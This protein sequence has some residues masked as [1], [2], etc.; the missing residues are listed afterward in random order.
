MTPSDSYPPFT[1]RTQTLNMLNTSAFCIV[2]EFFLCFVP[3]FQAQ[4]FS[5]RMAESSSDNTEIRRA[6]NSVTQNLLSPALQAQDG[7]D[8]STQPSKRKRP[9]D[10]EDKEN[11]SSDDMPKNYYSYGRIFSRQ[12]CPFNT[13]DSIVNFGIRHEASDDDDSD[14]EPKTL[15]TLE[16]HQLYGWKLICSVIPGFCI[17]MLALAKQRKVRKAACQHISKGAN[18]VRSDDTASL[19]VSIPE[20]LLLNVKDVLSPPMLSKT[21][22]KNDRG[23]YHPVT[24][25][26]LSPVKYPKD[27]LT[28]EGIRAGTLPVTAQLL[29]S[30]L[31]PDGHVYDPNDISLN[32][33]RGH[34]MIRVAKH[35][36]QGPSTALEQ[37]GAHRGKQGNASLCGLTTMTPHTIAYVAIQARFAMTSTSTWANIDGPFSYSDFYWRIVGLFEDE[38]EAADIIKFYNHH[39]F[40]TVSDAD[41]RQIAAAEDESEDEYEI[42]RRQ[43]SA[44]RA[45]KA[46]ERSGSVEA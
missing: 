3:L 36:F 27:P 9:Q 15:T 20:Y 11:D 28:I 4:H 24:A 17:D 31:F 1:S 46:T 37:P 43:R 26:L 42:V 44:K 35:L 19:K 41:T 2:T 39:V 23:F 38:E 8:I 14:I 21:K 13:V 10:P 5:V 25:A 45:R 40:G 30:F 32:V 22:V 6:L 34:V 18:A 12:S 33:L 7:G 29:P 16:E